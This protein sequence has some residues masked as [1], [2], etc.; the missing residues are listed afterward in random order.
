M[1]VTKLTNDALNLIIDSS[2]EYTTDS[3]VNEAKAELARRD[4]Q[5]IADFKAMGGFAGARRRARSGQYR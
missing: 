1:N 4:K 2:D 5:L 3:R